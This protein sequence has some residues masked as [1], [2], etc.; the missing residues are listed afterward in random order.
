MRGTVADYAPLIRPTGLSPK[1][2]PEG[3]RRVDAEDAQFLG[4]EVQ[5]LEREGK[6]AV[7]GMPIDIGIELG[8]EETALDHVALELGHVDAVGGEPAERL[9]ERGGHVAHLKQKGG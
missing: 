5:L 2:L 1:C 6:P 9:V 7:V 8:G 3:V 4:E